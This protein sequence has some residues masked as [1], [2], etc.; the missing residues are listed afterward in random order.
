MV[1]S[2]DIAYVDDVME[3]GSPTEAE[4]DIR[5]LRGEICLLI[6]IWLQTDIKTNIK[7]EKSMKEEI[8]LL[9]E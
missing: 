5:L 9:K 2:Q 7:G 6:N 1:F 4:N 8:A 3:P